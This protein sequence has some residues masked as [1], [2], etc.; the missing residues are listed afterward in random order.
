MNKFGHTFFQASNIL[1][2]KLRVSRDLNHL[3]IKLS[4]RSVIFLMHAFY[5]L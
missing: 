1:K 4:Y 3:L 5:K 2:F